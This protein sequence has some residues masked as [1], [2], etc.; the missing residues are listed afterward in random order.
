MEER[1]EFFE[2]KDG[3]VLVNDEKEL[4]EFCELAGWESVEQFEQEHGIKREEV[5]GRKFTTVKGTICFE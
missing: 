4:A 1:N 3:C 5:F 2:T